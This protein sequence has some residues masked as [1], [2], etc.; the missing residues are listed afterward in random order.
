MAKIY[1][2]R[3]RAYHLHLEYLGK[4]ELKSQLAVSSLAEKK[5]NIELI[6][7]PR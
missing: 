4:W 5:L 2:K 7:F 3:Q 1:G 6:S